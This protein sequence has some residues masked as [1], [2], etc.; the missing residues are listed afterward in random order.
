[1][2]ETAITPPGVTPSQQPMK[3][4]RKSVTPVFRQV[5]PDRE[6]DLE[7]DRGCVAASLSAAPIQE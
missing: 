4:E 5:F 2:K 3:E 6:H 1:M 7:A